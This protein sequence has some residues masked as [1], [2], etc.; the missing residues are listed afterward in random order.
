MKQDIEDTLEAYKH[1]YHTVIEKMEQARIEYSQ[2]MHDKEREIETLGN[3]MKEDSDAIVQRVEQL[4]AELIDRDEN[5]Q[6]VIADLKSKHVRVDGIL[7]REVVDGDA[8][9]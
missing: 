5:H 9:R 3:N 8:A 4:E 1:K 7:S 6:K 2:R